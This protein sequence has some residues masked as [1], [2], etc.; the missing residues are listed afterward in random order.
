MNKPQRMISAILILCIILA[1]TFPQMNQSIIPIVNAEGIASAWHNNSSLNVQIINTAPR[2][3]W[4]DFQ[5]NDSGT[6]VS[7]LN[8]RIEVNNNSEYRFVINIS[9]DQGWDDIEF[10]NL[11]AWYDHGNESSIYNQTGNKGGNLNLHMQYENTSSTSN[12]PMFRNLWPDDE[13]RFGLAESRVVE[14]S[15]FGL[16]GV[17]EARNI[18]LPFI[19]NKQFRYAPG[20]QENW[21]TSVLF[22]VENTSY[23]GLYN[24]YSWNFN[25]TVTDSGEDNSGISLTTWVTDEF[26]VYAYSEILSATNPSIIGAPNE[27]FS[28]LDDG[29]SGNISI[30]T[31]SNGNYN[32]SVT[33]PDLVHEYLSTHTIPKSNVYVRGGNRSTFSSLLDSVYLYG[34]NQDGM[35]DYHI[36]SANNNFVN[37][38][39]VEYKCFIPMGQLAG[40][41]TNHIYYHLS[42]EE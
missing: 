3:N 42:I 30:V 28:V 32:L 13:V 17:T 1:L 25:I 22:P 29:G 18:T 16:N 7:R 26:G 11:T 14:D 8:Q 27:N 10:I 35:S 2:I 15:M 23:Y 4:Y 12:S 19:P 21:N 6:W 5:Y 34:G 40:R 36:A 39:N 41:Y 37:T 9:S 38:T 33:L 31:C 20:E 24:N